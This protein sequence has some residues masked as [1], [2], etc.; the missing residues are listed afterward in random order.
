MSASQSGFELWGEVKPLKRIGLAAGAILASFMLLCVTAS[1]ASAKEQVGFYLAGAASEEIAKQPRFEAEKYTT[2]LHGESTTAH[3]Y[4][5][6]GGTMECPYA[7]FFGNVTAKTSELALSTFYPYF[8]C[9][10]SLGAPMTINANGC[11]QLVTVSNAGPPY[12]GKWGMKCPGQPYRFVFSLGGGLTC[13]VGI[14]PQTGRDK[15]SYENT[16]E[17]KTRAVK[18]ALNVSGIKY[19]LTSSPP[20]LE[21]CTGSFENGTYTGSFTLKGYNEP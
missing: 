11:E 2:Y 15:V 8:A 1:S 20:G 19:T 9:S 10:N 12:V 4:G 21:G 13:A 17:G 16:G 7:E 14:L 5:F 6:Q 18:V 3:K